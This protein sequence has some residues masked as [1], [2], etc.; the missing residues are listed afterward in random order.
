VPPPPDLPDFSP[1]VGAWT[2][3]EFIVFGAKTRPNYRVV[4]AAFDP[5]RGSWRTIEFRTDG[6]AGSRES[7]REAS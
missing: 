2:G 5:K 7:G 1:A 4:G 6:G 3:T